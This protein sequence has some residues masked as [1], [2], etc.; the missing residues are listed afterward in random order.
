M[1]FSDLIISTVN[2]AVDSFI[3]QV[4]DK[5]NISGQELRSLWNGNQTKT[6]TQAKPK[7]TVETEKVTEAAPALTNNSELSGLK[8]PELVALCKTRGLSS[9]GTKEEMIARLTGGGAPA[10]KKSPPKPAKVDVKP[11]LKSVQTKIEPFK[12][13][14]NS[15]GNHEHASTGLVLD[16]DTKKI[17]GTQNPKGHIDPLTD[18]GIEICNKYKLQYVLPENLNTKKAT[19]VEDLP[20]EDEEDVGEEIE[21]IEDNLEEEQDEDIEDGDFEEEELLEEADE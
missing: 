2:K 13:S 19:V 3:E 6:Q 9:T 11:V 20:D 7:K 5:Y 4:A 14:K 15:F 1:S 12:V 21:D 10:K 8:K 18:E 17:I 16:K